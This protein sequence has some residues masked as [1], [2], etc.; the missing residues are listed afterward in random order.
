M[1]YSLTQ[2]ADLRK[3]TRQNIYL[4]IKSKKLKAEMVGNTYVI[5]EQACVKMWGEKWKV[6]E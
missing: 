1:K 3:C 6:Q 4:L 5:S 2:V